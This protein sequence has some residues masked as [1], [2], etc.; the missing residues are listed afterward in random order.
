MKKCK[1]E[2][3][4]GGFVRFDY[5]YSATEALE[6]TAQNLVRGMDEI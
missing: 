2:L 3:E 6:Q 1:M 4:I 5:A